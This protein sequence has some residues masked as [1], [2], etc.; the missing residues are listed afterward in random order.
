MN[1]F[2]P[3]AIIIGAVSFFLQYATDAQFQSLVSGLLPTPSPTVQP[4][5]TPTQAPQVLGTQELSKT[6]VIRI[7]DGDTVEIEG[8]LRLRYIGVDTAEIGSGKKTDE[9]YAREAKVKNEELVLNKE[10]ELEKDVSETDRFGRLLRYVWVDGKMINEELV[11]SGYAKVATFPPDVKYK[12]R[13]LAAEKQAREKGL[14]LWGK[15]GVK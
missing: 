9:C 3:W 11:A 4:S 13:F 2:L 7:V 6:K 8:G 10:V 12:D 14:G 1:K 15:C 5:P